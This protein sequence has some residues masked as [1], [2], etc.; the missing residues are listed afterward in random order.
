[1]HFLAF[2]AA[3]GASAVT[4]RVYHHPS[5][6]AALALAKGLVGGFGFG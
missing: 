5:L 2:T 4:Q 6:D 1:M 3:G